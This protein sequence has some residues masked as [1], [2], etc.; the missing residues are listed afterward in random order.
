MK[1]QIAWLLLALFVLEGVTG[2]VPSINTDVDPNW[3]R[4]DFSRCL[5]NTIVGIV[6][7][8]SELELMF[9]N[10]HF[11]AEVTNGKV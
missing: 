8:L 11:F 6:N 4:C 3:S 10:F 5:F 7:S 1:D 2:M 9:E